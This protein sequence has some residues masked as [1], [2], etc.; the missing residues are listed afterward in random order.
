MERRRLH[1]DRRS[2]GTSPPPQSGERAYV[3][4][5][6]DYL[7]RTHAPGDDVSALAHCRDAGI[8]PSFNFMLFDPDCSLDDFGDTL[9]LAE[10]HLDLPWRFFAGQ[11]GAE[12][13]VLFSGLLSPDSSC[14]L[15]QAGSLATSSP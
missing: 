7:G 1:S 12:A 3:P 14:P 5:P 13:D 6:V 11:E 15:S 9:K 2:R 10:S 8:V 4:Q